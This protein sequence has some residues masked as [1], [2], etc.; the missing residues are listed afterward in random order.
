MVNESLKK[1][2]QALE[3]ESNRHKFVLEDIQISIALL[4]QEIKKLKEDMGNGEEG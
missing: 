1:R 2:I 4:T 3:R